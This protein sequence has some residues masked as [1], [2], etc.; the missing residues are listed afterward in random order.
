M[1][2]ICRKT[3]NKLSRV[4]KEAGEILNEKW[5]LGDENPFLLPENNLLLD[6]L[7]YEAYTKRDEQE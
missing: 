7:T 2:L 6:R 5:R 4:R 3:G 1:K